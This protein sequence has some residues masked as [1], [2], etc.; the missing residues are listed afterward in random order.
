[1]TAYGLA[2]KLNKD[3]IVFN[4]GSLLQIPLIEEMRKLYEENELSFEV[5]NPK[6]GRFKSTSNFI[7]RGIKNKFHE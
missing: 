7:V 3:N 6:T 1:M 4:Q 2:K 5:V